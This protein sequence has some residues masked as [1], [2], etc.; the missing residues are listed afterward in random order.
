MCEIGNEAEK[1]DTRDRTQ[2]IE[3]A[4]PPGPDRDQKNH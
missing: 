1:I 4:L 2:R 3:L